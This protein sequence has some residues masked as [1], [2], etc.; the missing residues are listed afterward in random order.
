MWAKGETVVYI[1]GHTHCD[2]PSPLRVGDHVVIDGHEPGWECY[3]HPDAACFRVVG[4]PQHVWCGY[5]FRKPL[6]LKKFFNVQEKERT[7]DYV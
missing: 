7:P 1:D 4:F 5:C 3:S 2:S 6:N